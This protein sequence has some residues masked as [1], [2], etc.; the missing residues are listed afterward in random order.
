MNSISTNLK[1][2]II[3]VILFSNFQVVKS[4]EFKDY[5]TFGNLEQTIS[6][7]NHRNVDEIVVI[8]IEASKT[9]SGINLNVLKI[10]SR[11]SIMPFS[12]G[13]GIQNI[14]DIEKCLKSGC[15]KVVINTQSLKNVKF[16]KEAAAVFG[17][18]CIIISVDYKVL[19]K[20]KWEIYSHAGLQTKKI[21]LLKY[22]ME[23]ENLGAGEL[24]LT[25][26]N[27]DGKMDGYDTSLFEK[28]SK[29]ITIPVIINGGCGIPKH[30]LD[31]LN[32]G[33]SGVSAGSIFYFSQ[34]SYQ[35]IK[36]F[37]LKNKIQVRTS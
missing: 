32:C 35:D 18:Q 16:V 13:G 4:R 15:D 12:Y 17:S 25:S 10:L 27:H 6:V 30:M 2:R 24:I 5:R 19:R 34:Y 37:L 8:D 7:F 14:K 23:L 1:K 20:D 31:P 9:K 3:P 29:K 33:A 22:L 21:H 26:V 11:N 28:I 36:D